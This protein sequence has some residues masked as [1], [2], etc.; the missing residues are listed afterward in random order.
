MT[1]LRERMVK[2]LQLAR[3]AANTQQAYVRAVEGLA[4]YYRRPPDQ[5]SVEEI[6]DYLRHQLVDLD[7]AWSTCNVT[8]CGLIFLYTRVLGWEGL[9]LEL[10]TRKRPKGLPEVLSQEEVARLLE[11]PK[12]PKHRALLKTTYSAGL[13]VSEVVH[14]KLE[15]VD[16][17]RMTIR[18]RQSKGWKDRYV[19]LSERLVVE[20]RDYWKIR[21]PPV[22][23]FPGD[24][25]DRPM[26]RS[27]AHQAYHRAR[28]AAG[29][30]RGRGI[31]TLRHC[32]ATH[33]LEN[34]ADSTVI[35]ELL[36]HAYIATTARYLHVAQ[37]HL[38]TIKSPLDTLPEVLPPSR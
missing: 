8:M 6:R 12:N 25:L 27:A 29:I 26:S 22:W 28:M 13:R 23:L 4:R 32:F 37:R 17:K 9:R 33:L 24:E 19:G 21:R 35:K 10:P 16:S 38:A 11:A 2:E 18:V 14:L 36:G 31:H 15:D 20:L 7:L 34:G 3:K 5:I 30:T 1:Q